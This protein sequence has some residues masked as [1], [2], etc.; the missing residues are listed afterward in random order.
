MQHFPIFL[1]LAD[2]PVVIAGN[3]AF[4]L[5]KMRL[6]SKTQ[7]RLALYAPVPEADLE[8]AAAELAVPLHRR[9]VEAADLSGAALAYAAHG[10][11]AADARLAGLARAAG[12]IVNVVDNL[13]ASDFITPAIVDRDPVTI[14][15]GTEGAA[16]VLAR[17]IKADLEATLPVTLG[18]LARAGK[19]FRP[20]AEALP[21]GRA[22]R[23]FWADYYFNTGPL[24]LAEAGEELLDHALH[25]LL[26]QHL[27][28]ATEPGRVDLVGAGPGDP[29]LMTLKARR[30]LDG[31]DVVIHDHLV[32]AAILELAR[33]EAIFV[34]VGKI[35]F[36]P[37]TPQEDINAAMIEHAQAGHRVVRLK[38]GDASV[39]G[40]LDEETEALSAAGIDWSVT[41]GITAASAAAASIGASLTRRGRNS[42]LRL[43]TAHDVSGFADHDWRA[44]ARPGAVA[45]IYMG[46]RAAR[47]VQGRLLMHGADGQTPVTL[48]ENVS[49]PDQRIVTSRLDQLP[50]DIAE[51]AFAGPVI[52]LFGL[53]PARA[54]AVLPALIEEFA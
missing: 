39:F 14:A 12:V 23:D 49:R 20:H 5:A 28:A 44:L 41:P 47:F 37:S 17:K 2:R 8:S 40:R 52:T 21:Q 16:P 9:S 13:E 10:E 7:A 31:A 42:D 45:A 30:L 25:A 32:P 48:V 53:A 1:D 35:G 34:G 26:D 38:G 46:K 36:A 19:L 27:N 33:R 29:E 22:R 18:P 54:A 50:Q 24:V 4:A 43:L 15:I 6:L 3:G 51:A 11:A